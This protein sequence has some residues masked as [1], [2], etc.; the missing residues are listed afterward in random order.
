[1]D[2][3]SISTKLKVDLIYNY[4][5][6]KE[7]LSHNAIQRLNCVIGHFNVKYVENLLIGLT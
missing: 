7:Y 3:K 4:E 2:I 6:N 5:K 1:M